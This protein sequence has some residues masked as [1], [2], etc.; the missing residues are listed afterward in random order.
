MN[1]LSD[2][3]LVLLFESE[4]D[5]AWRLFLDRHADTIL[6]RL[7][8]SGFD[9][10]QAMDRFVYVCEK[11]CA[12]SFRRLRAVRYAGDHGDLTPWLGQVVDRMAVSWAWSQEGRRRLL[13]PIERLS[14]RDQQIFQLHFWRGLAPGEI[15]AALRGQGDTRVKVSDVLEG[16]ERIF[17]RLSQKKLWRLLSNLAR[18]RP[19]LSLSAEEPDEIPWELAASEP[20]PEE[21]LL[22]R[23]A[24]AALE[25][26]FAGL[27]TREQLALRLRF[28]EE[29]D[30]AQIARVLALPRREARALLARALRALREC[31]RKE[32]SVGEG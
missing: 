9:Y 32:L 28:E 13:R 22:A 19:A 25:R 29:L 26:A 8:R 11:L 14:S 2:R 27:G 6:T 24:S 15:Y 7:R 17:A 12:D 4:P 10:D 16:L 20:S 21:A 30:T 31:L 18:R 5:R 1:E 3:E 23:E